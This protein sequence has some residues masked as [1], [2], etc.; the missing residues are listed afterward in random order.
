MSRYMKS[1][2]SEIRLHTAMIDQLPVVV[3][4]GD[5]LV[6][7]GRIAEITEISVKIGDERYVREVCT[8][9]YAS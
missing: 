8:F 3:F 5:E 6:G 1:L 7:A 9:R 4:V 2:T